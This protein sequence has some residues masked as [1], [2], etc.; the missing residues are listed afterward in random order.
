MDIL[1][2]RKSSKSNIPLDKINKETINFNEL[3]SSINNRSQVLEL[4]KFLCHACHPDKYINDPNKAQ[5]AEDLFKKV[6]N[7]KTDLSELLKIQDE[8]NE[9]LLSR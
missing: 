4:Y 1:F 3:F 9:K 8:A 5:I 2:W 6:Q 7:C